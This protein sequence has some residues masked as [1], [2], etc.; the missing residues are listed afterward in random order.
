MQVIFCSDFSSGLFFFFCV[1]RM[2]FVCVI[3]CSAFNVT[4]CLH[5]LRY[6]LEL[7]RKAFEENVIVV[8]ETGCGK[9]LIAILLM[10]DMAHLINNPLKNVCVF[11]APTVVLV[12]QVRLSSCRL[13]NQM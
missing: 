2:L 11:L 8:L 6:Q 10:C 4:S 7:A 5:F 1:C 3:S 12:R 13:R 9:T